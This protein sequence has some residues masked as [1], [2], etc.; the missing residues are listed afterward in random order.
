[1]TVMRTS[2][3]S[4]MVMTALIAFPAAARAQRRPDRALFEGGYGDSEQLLSLGVTFGAGETSNVLG[5]LNSPIQTNGIVEQGPK[6]TFNQ[7]SASL[8]YSLVRPRAGISGSF[9]QTAT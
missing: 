6:S 8:V 1:M 3:L 7:A 5:G 4:A 9:F 2:C